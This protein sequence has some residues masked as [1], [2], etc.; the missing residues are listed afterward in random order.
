MLQLGR[1]RVHPA[2]CFNSLST[3]QDRK[4]WVEAIRVAGISSASL[5]TDTG[6]SDVGTFRVICANEGATQS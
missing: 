5:Q 4:E 3:Q 2:V 1:P 6:G